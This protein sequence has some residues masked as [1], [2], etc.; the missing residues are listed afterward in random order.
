MYS[1]KNC[2]K[3]LAYQMRYYS[4]MPNNKKLKISDLQDS[5]RFQH[6]LDAPD[7]WNPN[8]NPIRTAMIKD[9]NRLSKADLV[10]LSRA[11]YLEHANRF[12]VGTDLLKKSLAEL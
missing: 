6:S 1:A 9:L 3:N 12:N 4:T 5:N 8:H 7:D 11:S 2:K 10:R